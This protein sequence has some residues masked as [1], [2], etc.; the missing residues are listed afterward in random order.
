MITGRRLH[1]ALA[2]CVALCAGCAGVVR[3]PAPQS[4]QQV[5]AERT[6][7]FDTDGDGRPDYWQFAGADGR[8]TA[9]A[10]ALPG[11]AT[12]G[13][14]INL[15]DQPAA[16]CPH[17]LIALDGVPFD[18]VADLWQR[19]HFRLFRPPAR[20]ICCFPSMTDL[21]LAELFHAGPCPGY[22]A[23]HFD[24]GANR[25]SDSSAVYLSGRSSP[26]LA[27]MS[28]RCSL[29]WDVLVYL[30][31]QPVFDHE[32]Q[33]MLRTFRGV[34]SGAAYAYSV[35]TAGLGTRGG[36]PAI[37]KYLLA[38][39]RLCEQLV[40]ERQGRVKLTL[41]ADHGHNL[42]ANQRVSF[43]RRLRAAGYR[44]ARAL[45]GPHDVVPIAYGLV[46]YA[47]FHTTD[48][49]GV[50]RCL[51]QDDSVEFAAYP[52][53]DVIEIVDRAGTARL[54]RGGGG[55]RYEPGLGDPLRLNGI[56]A[57]MKRDGHVTSAGDIDDEA[58]FQATLK[59]YYPDPLARLWRAFHGQVENPP[60]VIANLRD[61]AC[62]G[63]GFFYAMVGG[64]VASTH[65]ALNAR[66]STTFALTT[67]G[68]LPPGLRSADVLPALDRFRAPR[69]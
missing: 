22:E 12:P 66:N 62:H 20:V 60:D 29:W 5:D 37:E 7:A 31:P 6:L 14:R 24:R 13:P 53:G 48:A 56:I 58:I 54:M 38:I 21:A 2:T 17:L 11:T 52:A 3:F 36:R 16:D 57:R 19:G 42:V 23:L 67:L 49:P 41:T 9:L 65:G 25:L 28:Y 45:H 1:L 4:T 51:V 32:V 34:Q 40:F 69:P 68:E 55:W 63:S 15:D 44:P 46:T 18:V 10:Y 50:A 8:K 59:H 35:G 47:G 64:R 43:N 27:Q 61:G 30:N 39:D 26:W 33:G